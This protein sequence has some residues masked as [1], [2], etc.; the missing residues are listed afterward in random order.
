MQFKFLEGTWNSLSESCP[1]LS[2]FFT[3]ARWLSLKRA[4]K[5]LP[6]PPSPKILFW[7]K[8]FV[9]DSSNVYSITTTDP[10]FPI[11][12]LKELNLPKIRPDVIPSTPSKHNNRRKWRRGW[13]E[14]VISTSHKFLQNKR[15]KRR[16]YLSS[17]PPLDQ[18]FVGSSVYKPKHKMKA[19]LLNQQL[20]ELWWLP[21]E[22][23][24]PSDEA[25]LLSSAPLKKSKSFSSYALNKFRRTW[26]FKP[27]KFTKINIGQ[28]WKE[29]N[30]VFIFMDFI[31][32]SIKVQR[33]KPLRKCTDMK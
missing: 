4:L 10:F 28:S 20:Q 22:I 17:L 31:K 18:S 13:K 25:G 12:V 3:A 16:A 26:R 14:N 21:K 19:R 8:L 11:P 30:F 33:K 23:L 2:I 27:K 1:P 5:T 7:L 29:A 6:K 15:I 32:N 9:A 24:Y